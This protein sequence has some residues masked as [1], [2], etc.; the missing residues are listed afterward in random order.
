MFT[1][2]EK[3][4]YCL[5]LLSKEKY[6]YSLP[7]KYGQFSTEGIEFVSKIFFLLLGERGLTFHNV[8]FSIQLK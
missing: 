7:W 5:L 2:Y 1:S 3:V 8:H 6:F 4:E